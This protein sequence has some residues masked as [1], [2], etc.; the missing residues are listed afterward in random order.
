MCVQAK[1]K[2]VKYLHLCSEK[3]RRNYS[4]AIKGL[5]ERLLKSTRKVEDEQTVSEWEEKHSAGCVQQLVAGL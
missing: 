3:V 1:Q 4:K 2:H 5:E